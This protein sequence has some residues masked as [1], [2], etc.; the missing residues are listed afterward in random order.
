MK[1]PKGTKLPRRLR[2]ELDNVQVAVTLAEGGHFPFQTRTSVGDKSRLQLLQ[3]SLSKRSPM[4]APAK[5]A[6][7]EDTLLRG[8]PESPGQYIRVTQRMVG[9]FVILLLPK[10]QSFIPPEDLHHEIN[11]VR[12]VLATRL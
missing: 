2:K 11:V 7:P 6:S 5:H 9:N 1:L 4:I 3:G 10:S 12:A 8:F